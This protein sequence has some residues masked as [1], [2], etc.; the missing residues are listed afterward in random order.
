M[1]LAAA[2]PFVTEHQSQH[3]W[4]PQ[5]SQTLPLLTEQRMLPVAKKSA[6]ASIWANVQ[7]V[8]IASS[9]TSVGTPTARVTTLARGAPSGIELQRAHTPLRHSQ[10][11]RELALHPDKAYTL[12]LLTALQHGVDIGYKAPVGP[13]DAKNL[14]S[15]FQHSHILDHTCNK[16]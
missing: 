10:F 5:L 3:T 9:P 1:L 6:N 15:A 16:Y 2:C 7:K 11:E 4:V 12:Q 8:T 13:N 14:P